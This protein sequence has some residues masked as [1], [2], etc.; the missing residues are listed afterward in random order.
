MDFIVE[1]FRKWWGNKLYRLRII[2]SGIVAVLAISLVIV[3]VASLLGSSAT[4]NPGALTALKC[5]KCGFSE[6]R[7][8]VSLDDPSV[9][10][11][12]CGGPVSIRMKCDDC[13][14]EFPKRSFD[15]IESI[16]GKSKAEA[17]QFI[18]SQ[19]VCPNC[20]STKTGSIPGVPK[21]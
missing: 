21:Q 17:C 2:L 20:N 4:D 16:K 1:T 11:S 6:D 7:C 19:T 12:K 8:I 3:F 15:T 13:G 9:K 5:V 18:L 14:F 10:C